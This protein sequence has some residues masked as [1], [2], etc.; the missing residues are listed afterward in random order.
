MHIIWRNLM[1]QSMSVMAKIAVLIGVALVFGAVLVTLSVRHVRADRADDDSGS[2][3]GGGRKNLD[4]TFN[5]Q[6]DGTLELNA[7]EGDVTVTGGDSNLVSVEVTIDGNSKRV[8]RYDVTMTQDGNTVRIDGKEDR[9]FFQW[10]ND[11]SFNVHFRISVPAKF[12]LNLKTEGGDLVISGVTGRTS[13]NTSGGNLEVTDYSG[14]VKLETSGGDIRLQHADGELYLRTSGGNIRGERVTGSL[15]VETSGGDIRCREIDAKLRASTS[16]GN[17]EVH[18]LSNKG[19]DLGTS[20][21][22]VRITIP[23]DAKADV[24][25]ETTG[26]DVSCEMDFN[27]KIKDGRMNGRING[28]GNL[29]TARTSGG[30]IVVTSSE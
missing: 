21:G 8:D 15:D 7:D 28:G 19:V 23:R 16:G 25:A 9:K 3:W 12:N 14:P 5:V 6:P 10:F 27:G 22:N 17:I 13:G 20:G 26:G 1:N 4:K 30:D 11:G 24:D 2:P 18:L 29:I